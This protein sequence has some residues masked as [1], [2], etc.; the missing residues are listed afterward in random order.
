MDMEEALGFLQQYIDK[1][2]GQFMASDVR[3]FAE[4]NG[5]SVNCDTRVWGAVM[6]AASKSGIIRHAGYAK[7]N[8]PKAHKSPMSVWV[9]ANG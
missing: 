4:K 9:G 5:F 7:S 3:E 2:G 8:N 6:N 1:V